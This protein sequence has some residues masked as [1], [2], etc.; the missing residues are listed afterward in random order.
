MV[1]FGSLIGL[2]GFNSYLSHLFKSLLLYYFDCYIFD[3]YAFYAWF[4]TL[5]SYYLIVIIWYLVTEADLI[6]LLV[7]LVT[8][9]LC[10][11]LLLGTSYFCKKA[12]DQC[13]G[14]DESEPQG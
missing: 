12:K 14:I 13:R 11:T 3:Y 2:Q 8:L 7:L 9:L 6:I 10:L 4:G 1:Y 5:M